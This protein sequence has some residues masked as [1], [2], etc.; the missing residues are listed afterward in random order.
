VRDGKTSTATVT[1]ADRAKLFAGLLGG[2]PDAAAPDPTTTSETK[3]GVTV[4]AIPMD[5]ASK[6]GIPGGVQVTG[7]RPGSF[8]DD[9]ALPK[10]VVIISINRKPVTDIAS[11]NAVV[12]S[13]KSG[14]D[15]V[16]IVRDPANKAAGNTYVGGTLP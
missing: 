4:H 16:F 2:S 13:L 9:I 8:A 6:L 5:L 15:V 14:D 3:L 12:N 7:V 10:G 1:I 11:Y